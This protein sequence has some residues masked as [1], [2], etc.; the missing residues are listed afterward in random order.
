M[1]RRRTKERIAPTYG[2]RKQRQERKHR[3]AVA[4]NLLTPL[5]DRKESRLNTDRH[6]FIHTPDAEAAR[7]ELAMRLHERIND[8]R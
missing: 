7:I 6:G 2:T 5:E 8:D 3:E 1:S 4:R